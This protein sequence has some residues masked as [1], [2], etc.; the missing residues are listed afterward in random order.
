MLIIACP[1]LVATVHF[2]ERRAPRTVGVR[3]IALASVTRGQL[4]QGKESARAKGHERNP[5]RDIPP[6]DGSMQSADPNREPPR[7]S[8]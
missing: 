5:G 1:L 3:T 2:G 4:P 7:P 6:R 8:R